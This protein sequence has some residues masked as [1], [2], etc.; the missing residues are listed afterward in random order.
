MDLILLVG[1]IGSIASIISWYIALPSARSR[2]VHVVYGLAITI[3][4][5]A[6]VYYYQQ[7][8]DARNFEIQ[9]ERILNNTWERDDRAVMLA[10]LS[11]LEKHRSS[12]P[13][14]YSAAR[15]LCVKAGLFGENG[16]DPNLGPKD[17]AN[18]M[19]GLL[20]GLGIDSEMRRA[21]TLRK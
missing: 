18:T 12:F 1:F 11:L 13:D 9:A 17:G 8:S 2:L 21:I 5:S 16:A 10:V 6:T 20:L 14:T 7:A 15:E 19:R 3:A 4:S